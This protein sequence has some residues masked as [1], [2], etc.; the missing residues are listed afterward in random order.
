MIEAMER[1][2]F[3]EKDAVN[4]RGSFCR[5]CLPCLS[6]SCRSWRQSP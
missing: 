3:G 4:A 1:Q 5:N 2:D 6:T